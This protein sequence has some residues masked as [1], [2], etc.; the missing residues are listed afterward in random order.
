MNYNTIFTI[1]RMLIYMI[2]Y[3][4]TVKCDTMKL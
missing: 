1:I 2:D 4:D 3:S